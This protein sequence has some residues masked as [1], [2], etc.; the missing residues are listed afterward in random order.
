[1]KNFLIISE[2]NDKKLSLDFLKEMASAKELMGLGSIIIVSSWH[3]ETVVLMSRCK[4][5]API[6][7]TPKEDEQGET[8]TKRGA[9]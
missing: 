2:S 4:P 6:E 8:Y 3:V 1:M 5:D 7:I 9:C